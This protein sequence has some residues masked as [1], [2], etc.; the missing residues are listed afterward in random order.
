MRKV[1]FI[2]AVVISCLNSTP[3]M[4]HILSKP[5]YSRHPC[6][7]PINIDVSQSYDQ[8]VVEQQLLE[9]YVAVYK[10]VWAKKLLFVVDDQ[11]RVALYDKNGK[12]LI[13]FMEGMPRLV[14]GFG[15]F[16]FMGD[17]SEGAEWEKFFQE[18]R[19]SY[20]T[21]HK[22]V[23]GNGR[24]VYSI[25]AKKVLIPDSTYDYITCTFKYPSCYFY[26][27]KY[28]DDDELKWG[29]YSTKK[30]LLPC[31]YNFVTHTPNPKGDDTK[32]MLEELENYKVSLALKQA[33]R[34]DR[35]AAM[36]QVAQIMSAA[37][38][39]MIATGEA[40]QTFQPSTSTSS[41]DYSSSSSSK[42]SVDQKS[43]SHNDVTSK[44]ADAKTY[45]DYES[46]LIQMNTY[47]AEKY[48]AASRRNIQSKMKAIRT[49]WEQRGYQMFH[50]AWEDWNGV[51]K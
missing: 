30:M 18:V 22:M 26:V 41:S 31:A 29:L 23:V 27:A 45:S 48:N 15:N 7:V 9:K 38:N 6:R 36:M 10:S 49:K 5:E 46:Q 28:N 25:D 50:S 37:G 24:A 44:N 35:Q 34:R 16:V 2:L 39:A 21:T 20:G 14:L 33:R 4:A 3:C 8:T 32:D 51:K 13:P 40:I 17:K 47:Y 42:E 1:F 19:E 12:E 11:D 43:S